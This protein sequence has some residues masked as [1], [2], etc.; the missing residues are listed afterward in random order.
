MSINNDTRW[1][2]DWASVFIFPLKF[3][4]SLLREADT[5]SQIKSTTT[6][7]KTFW[8]HVHLLR[9]T[10]AE[11]SPR[12]VHDPWQGILNS[13]KV[14]ICQ[15]SVKYGGVVSLWIMLLR[16]LLIRFHSVITTKKS[17]LVVSPLIRHLRPW[18]SKEHLIRGRDHVKTKTFLDYYTTISI[19]TAHQTWQLTI[20]PPFALGQ[21]VCSHLW[22]S[23]WHS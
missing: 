8:D 7:E 17:C 11:P 20:I 21:P 14:K 1:K 23:Y 12:T 13:C 15:C 18:L 5:T 4:F 16:A 22:P 19:T 9:S 6:T 3:H 10:K 2:P